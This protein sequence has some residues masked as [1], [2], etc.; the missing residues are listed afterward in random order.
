MSGPVGWPPFHPAF[1]TML[2]SGKGKDHPTSVAIPGIVL[3]KNSRSVVGVNAST[4]ADRPCC[5]ASL[6]CG[7]DGGIPSPLGRNDVRY[8]VKLCSDHLLLLFGVKIRPPSSGA[9]AV[10]KRAPPLA[11]KLQ[12]SIS[13]THSVSF[14]DPNALTIAEAALGRSGQSAKSIDLLR[15]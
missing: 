4:D 14:S 6:L 15:A 3:G 2:I 7:C 9:I 12:F 13:Q 5:E 11:S 1:S 8:G 10:R